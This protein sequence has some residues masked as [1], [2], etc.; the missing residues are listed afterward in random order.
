M[1]T[2]VFDVLI[3]KLEEQLTSTKESLCDGGAKNEAEYRELCGFIRGLRTAQREVKDLSRNF[4]E[5]D[6]DE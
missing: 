3:E 5:E 6:D 1:A 2:T 4:M